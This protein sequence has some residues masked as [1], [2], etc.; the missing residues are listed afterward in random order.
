MK[1]IVY[2]FIVAVVLFSGCGAN[3]I[4][5]N[6]ESHSETQTESNITSES[7]SVYVPDSDTSTTEMPSETES[8]TTETGTQDTQI[9]DTQNP[10]EPTEPETPTFQITLPE[11]ATLMGDVFEDGDWV[12]RRD[13]YV[14]TEEYPYGGRAELWTQAGWVTLWE[15]EYWGEGCAPF[16]PWNHYEMSNHEKIPQGFIGDAMFEVYGGTD[17]VNQ[18]IPADKLTAE[19][20]VLVFEDPKGMQEMGIHSNWVFLSKK[21]FTKEEALKIAESYVPAYTE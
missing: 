4:Y 13:G 1:R 14:V 17:V 12:I 16:I 11:G 10:E 15:G 2:I 8:A 18:N 3:E 9:P 20:W 21:C 6:T 7:E 19:C 5:E